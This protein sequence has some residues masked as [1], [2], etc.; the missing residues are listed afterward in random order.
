MRPGERAC[1]ADDDVPFTGFSVRNPSADQEWH[2]GLDEV[3]AGVF[4]PSC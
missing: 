3:F 4:Q 1:D 2:A